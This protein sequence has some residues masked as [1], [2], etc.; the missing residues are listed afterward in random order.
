[1]PLEAEEGVAAEA[2]GTRDATDGKK[3]KDPVHDSTRRRASMAGSTSSFSSAI[4]KFQA[5]QSSGLNSDAPP[6]PSAPRARGALGKLRAAANVARQMATHNAA[7]PSSAMP[8]H[9]TAGEDTS[10]IWK[11][12]YLWKQ[13]GGAK[14]ADGRAKRSLG[15]TRRKWDR[16]WFV[17]VE[18][19]RPLGS[20]VKTAVVC[21]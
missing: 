4:S 15:S 1:M 14:T 5:D 7:P 10:K 9:R 16:R 11:K 12:G 18:G 8:D 19:V 6:E 21:V 17:L 3:A 13:S 2:E 20:R